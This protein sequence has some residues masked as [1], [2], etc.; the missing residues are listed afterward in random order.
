MITPGLRALSKRIGGPIEF[1]VPR[2]YLEL[3]EHNPFV[4]ALGIKDLPAEWYRGG[5]FIDLTDCPASIVESRSAPKVTA[6]RIE[7]FARALGVSTRELRRHG[8]SRYSSHPRPLG[9]EPN[10]GSSRG[11]CKRGTSSPFRHLRPKAIDVERHVRSC[12]CTG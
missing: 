2:R 9:N 4:T 5:R 7:I 3:F 12:P 8:C 11:I 1:A 6:N 10:S